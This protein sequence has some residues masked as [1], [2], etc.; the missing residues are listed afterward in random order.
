MDKEK[1]ILLLK[2]IDFTLISINKFCI[3]Y[4]YNPKT[5]RKYLNEFNI[6]YNKRN[7]YYSNRNEKGQFV[8][9]HKQKPSQE[10]KILDK[11]IVENNIRV[12]NYKPELKFSIDKTI[13]LAKKLG[14]T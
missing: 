3:K 1:L 2:K 10:T 9:N 7:Y 8:S 11:K 14:Y 12:I 6:E 5:I 4:N 13:E